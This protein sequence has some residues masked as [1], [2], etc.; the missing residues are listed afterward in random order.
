MQPLDRLARLRAHAILEREAADDGAVADEI[1][2]GRATALPL[3]RLRPELVGHL[4]VALAQQDRAADRDPRAVERRLDTAAAHRPEVA[5]GGDGATLA[6]GGHDRTRERMLALRLDRSGLRQDRVAIVAG[7]TRDHV[8][9]AGER[10]GLVE[11]DDV[12]QAA[13]FEA[14]TVL[15]ED[16]AAG[17]ER[18]RDRDHEGNREP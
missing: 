5:R 18:G 10:A 3:L 12:D 2:D 13:A 4:E 16:A 17:R 9:A 11:Q 14:E 15:D 1:Q 7:D 8:L 6:R